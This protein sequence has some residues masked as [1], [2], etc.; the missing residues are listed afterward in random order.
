VAL[1]APLTDETRDQQLTSETTHLRKT[2]LR[3]RSH[4]PGRHL[5][6]K[7]AVGSE[8]REETRIH[9]V[10]LPAVGDNGLGPIRVEDEVLLERGPRERVVRLVPGVDIETLPLLSRRRSRSSGRRAPFARVRSHT[11]RSSAQKRARARWLGLGREGSAG[12]DTQCVRNGTLPKLVIRHR[13]C[14][15]RLS[16]AGSAR[17]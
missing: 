14:R 7:D 9:G 2:Y 16:L 10:E 8:T 12:G 1:L 17:A 15:F 6:S 3:P 4:R 11:G 13:A 5:R